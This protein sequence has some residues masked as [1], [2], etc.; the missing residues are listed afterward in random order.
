MQTR[1]RS[2]GAST[3]SVVYTRSVGGAA[4]T[5]L[6][7]EFDA[8]VHTHFDSTP[9]VINVVWIWEV[10]DDVNDFGAT[11]ATG[12]T[13]IASYVAHAQSKG[14]RVCVVTCIDT[15]EFDS[16]DAR[17]GYRDTVNASIRANS[18]GANYIADPEA[19]ANFNAAANAALNLQ[20]TIY[21]ADGIHIL[22]AGKAAAAP[23]LTA[24]LGY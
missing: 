6:T 15:T 16:P 17:A 18:A 11:G 24:P 14:W 1:L 21:S 20:G 10:I 4:T 19:N 8:Q 7:A 12:Y 13:H 22:T 23:L 2:N 5:D 9:G 3:S